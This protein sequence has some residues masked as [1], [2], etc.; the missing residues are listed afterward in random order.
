MHDS[1]HTK[2]APA[3]RCQK[4]TTCAFEKA[5]CLGV[6]FATKLSVMVE[7]DSHLSYMYSTFYETSVHR[8]LHEI[9]ALKE[10]L[11]A[12]AELYLVYIN[13]NLYCRSISHLKFHYCGRRTSALWLFTLLSD[14][15]QIG[16]SRSSAALEAVI[17]PIV[18]RT[19]A[20]GRPMALARNTARTAGR[21]PYNKGLPG[22]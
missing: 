1:P 15:H 18:A 4:R 20:D 14:H 22:S 16:K 12:P 10:P 8:Q 2:S 19:T 6:T 11:Y 21:S 3:L 17:R 7:F 13:S 5:V 9:C